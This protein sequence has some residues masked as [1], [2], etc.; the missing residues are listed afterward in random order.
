MLDA[1]L[2]GGPGSEA[3]RGSREVWGAAGPPIP[4]REV[5]KKQKM[6]QAKLEV[7]KQ[8]KLPVQS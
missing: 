3:S 4:F 8:K 2:P 5:K 7:K 1:T 6:G